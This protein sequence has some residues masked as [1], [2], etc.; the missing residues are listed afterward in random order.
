MPRGFAFTDRLGVSFEERP[1]PLDSVGVYVPGGRAFYPSSLL[2]GVVLALLLCHN[3]VD[4]WKGN[5][6]GLE[7]QIPWVSIIAIAGVTSVACV[8]MTLIPAWQASRVY[9]AEALRYE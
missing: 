5:M 6:E 1:V 3:Y 4:L 7:M 9:P 2:M 8:L